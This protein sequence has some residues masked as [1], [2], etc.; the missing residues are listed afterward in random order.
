M[1]ARTVIKIGEE[2]FLLR[3]VDTGFCHKEDKGLWRASK[4]TWDPKQGEFKHHDDDDWM[5][6]P[7]GQIM[8]REVGWDLKRFKPTDWGYKNFIR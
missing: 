7:E 1:K 2:Y 8:A 3:Y 6:S 4:V 5:I